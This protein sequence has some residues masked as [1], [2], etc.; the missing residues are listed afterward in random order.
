MAQRLA[1]TVAHGLN[2]AVTWWTD[3]IATLSER[4]AD[5]VLALRDNADAYERVDQCVTDRF[6]GGQRAR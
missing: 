1:P 5:A 6:T 2:A 3:Q 4:A